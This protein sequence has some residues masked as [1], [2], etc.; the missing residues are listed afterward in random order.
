MIPTDVYT[1]TLGSG[2]IYTVSLAADTGDIFLTKLFFCLI[3]LAVIDII[4]TLVYR[5]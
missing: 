3:A 5:R 2:Q 1:F 4:Y